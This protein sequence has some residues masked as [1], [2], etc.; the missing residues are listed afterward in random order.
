MN[1]VF[2]G[3]EVPE[4]L[5][6]ADITKQPVNYNKAKCME[7]KDDRLFLS[8]LSSSGDDAFTMQR[9]ANAINVNYTIETRPATVRNDYNGPMQ[10]FNRKGYM[11]SEVY[12]FAVVFVYTNGGESF[13]YHI[14]HKVNANP[15]N[16]STYASTEVYPNTPGDPISDAYIADGLAGAFVKH[17]RMPSLINEPHFSITSGESIRILGLNFT[18]IVIPASLQAQLSGYYIVRQR[19][20]VAANRSIVCQ[21]IAQR[22]VLYDATAADLDQPPI[23]DDY[24]SHSLFF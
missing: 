9:I 21:G 3:N 11:R 10:T 22:L 15:F 6:L 13:A 24:I 14:P 19:R 23:H 5:D 2:T 20:D 7:Q 16:L 17:H 4:T 18:N 8:N 12:S 1:V